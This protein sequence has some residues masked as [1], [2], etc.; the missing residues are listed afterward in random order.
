MFCQKRLSDPEWG[1][2][3]TLESFVEA[4]AQLSVTALPLQQKV[5]NEWQDYV[6]ALRK[7]LNL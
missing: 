2:P 4:A 6:Q 3:N 5:L 7:R 1:A